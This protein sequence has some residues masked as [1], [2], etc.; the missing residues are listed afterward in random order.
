MQFLPH[1]SQV[2]NLALLFYFHCTA[3]LVWWV[4]TEP[5]GPRDQL[6]PCLVVAFLL[7]LPDNLGNLG[8]VPLVATHL[9]F[10]VPRLE[11]HN[12]EIQAP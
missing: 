6:S 9:K 4:H 3:G 12:F 10:G 11:H 5:S 7:Y 8:M 2:R 1:L